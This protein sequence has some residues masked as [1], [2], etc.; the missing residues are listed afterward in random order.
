MLYSNIMKDG[1]YYS[2]FTENETVTVRFY[3]RDWE[4]YFTYKVKQILKAGF[5]KFF[6]SLVDK[7]IQEAELREL[8]NKCMCDSV[9]WTWQEVIDNSPSHLSS[10][11]PGI[12][13]WVKHPVTHHETNLSS[14]I[15]SLND[16]YKWSRDAIADWIESL[17]EVPVFSVPKEP[18]VKKEKTIE[19]PLVLNEGEYI[20]P[21]I[22]V[23]RKR[24][25]S[26]SS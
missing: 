3:N 9:E 17:D 7:G 19:N 18:V 26:F 10:K 2:I 5:E 25:L 21:T 4:I 8:K 6:K 20:Q 14:A 15:M 16:A 24:F 11:L 22:L 12:H 1:T 13:N 23:E